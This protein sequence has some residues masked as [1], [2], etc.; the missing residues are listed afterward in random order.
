MGM[1]AQHAEHLVFCF[2]Q[3]DIVI[4]PSDLKMD[5]FR[6]SGPGGQHVNKID[7]AVRL[8]HK[9]SGMVVE[10]QATPSQIRNRDQALKIL[11]TR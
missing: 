3:I 10:C 7:S 11:R 9:P 5:T 2:V 8:T 6:S 4:K 1:K